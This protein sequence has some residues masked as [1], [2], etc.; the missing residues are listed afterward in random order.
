MRDLM[1]CLRMGLSAYFVILSLGAFAIFLLTSSFSLSAL[2]HEGGPKISLEKQSV[3]AGLPMV[4]NGTGFEGAKEVS[5]TLEGLSGKVDVG[6]YDIA[7]EDFKIKVDTPMDLSAGTW[8][9]TVVGG[10]KKASAT[11]TITPHDMQKMNEMMNEEAKG[12]AVEEHHGKM[13]G[14]TQGQMHEQED[15]IALREMKGM[16]EAMMGKEGH[17]LH[18]VPL[19]LNIS[20][21]GWLTGIILVLSLTSLAAGAILLVKK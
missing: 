11:I 13:M 4:I 2:A 10:G 17:S 15:A 20:R 8:K 6:R 16:H 21:P 14:E 18:G 1:K 7:G 12:E 5:V 3:M 9:V 19:V